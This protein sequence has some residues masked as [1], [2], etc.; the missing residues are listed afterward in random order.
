VVFWLAEAESLSRGHFQEGAVEQSSKGRAGG[1][2]V[3]WSVKALVEDSDSEFSGR[4]FGE[5][6][7]KQIVYRL[8]VG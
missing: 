2:V 3:E 8:W 5:Q 7:E 1:T 6:L 4:V